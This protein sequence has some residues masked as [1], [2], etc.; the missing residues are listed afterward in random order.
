MQSLIKATAGMNFTPGSINPQWGLNGTQAPI[1]GEPT[2]TSGP[3]L[4][5]D[6][7]INVTANDAAS[8]K[9]EL[10]RKIRSSH[11]AFSIFNFN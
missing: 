10:R 6:I 1:P 9:D 8:L 5:G 3:V 7:N 2:V 11:T 4:N